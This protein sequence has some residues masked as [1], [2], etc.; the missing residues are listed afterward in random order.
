MEVGPTSAEHDP[1]LAEAGPLEANNGPKLVEIGPNLVKTGPH[2]VDNGPRS[3]MV[4]LCFL[5]PN[6]VRS[7]NSGLGSTNSGPH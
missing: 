6:F 5:R 3:K 7:A 2:V 1:S 4:Q